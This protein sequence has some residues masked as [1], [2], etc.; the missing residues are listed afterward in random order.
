[1]ILLLR[2]KFLSPFMFMNDDRFHYS[3]VTLEF[4]IIDNL[5]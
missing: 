5:L 1:M 4:I 2:H 3:G